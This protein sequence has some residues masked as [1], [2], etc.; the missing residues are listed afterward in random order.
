MS[1]KTRPDAGVG[2]PLGEPGDTR[3]QQ[4]GADTNDAV[5]DATLSRGR[6]S[7]TEGVLQI[8][9]NASPKRLRVGAHRQTMEHG[10]EFHVRDFLAGNSRRARAALTCPSSRAASCAATFFP[11]AVMR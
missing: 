10:A 4:A 5:D 3:V 6:N 1:G 9:A 8:V 7:A 11:C 2:R